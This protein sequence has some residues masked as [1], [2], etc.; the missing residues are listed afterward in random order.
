MRYAMIPDSLPAVAIPLNKAKI[1]LLC[2]GSCAF[3]GAGIWMW[4]IAETASTL[5]AIWLTG[6]GLA[7]VSFFGLCG[8]YG[9]L[10]LF[11]FRPGLTIDAEGIVDN[12]SAVAVGRIPWNDVKGF[13]ICEISG[14]RF[15]VI[16]VFNPESYFKR[17]GFFARMM[18]AANKDLTGS[19]INISSNSLAVNFD[20]LVRLLAEAFARSTLSRPTKGNFP[21]EAE[22]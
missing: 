2:L 14:Q 22:A 17:G 15:V 9:L 13:R 18:N 4:H 8:V 12:S 19:P 1:V 16:E 5:D 21:S 11:D 20:E 10:K 7:N 3:V 6:V